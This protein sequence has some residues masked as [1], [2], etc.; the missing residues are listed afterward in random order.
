M[1]A[2]GIDI[3]RKGQLAI[4]T[5]NRPGKKNAFDE[6][7]WDALEDVTT[8]LKEKTP[9]AVIVTGAGEAFSAGFDVN[10]ENPQVSRLVDAVKNRDRSPV[11][12]L[13]NRIRTAVD[14]FVF[15]PVPVIAAVN[16]LAYGGGAELATR[17]DMRIVDPDA[18]FCF[19]ETRLGLMPDWGGGVAL[20]RL[21]GSSRAA[22][23]ILTARKVDAAEAAAMGMVN[24]TSPPGRSL[25]EAIE[26]AERIAA[27]GPSAIRHA[28]SVIR[29]S[30]DL[31]Q[32]NALQLETD[33]AVS[34]ITS[35]EC[36][37]GIM[38]FMNNE[39]PDFPDPEEQK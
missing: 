33:E 21:I 36:Y 2:H 25:D 1:S 26:M 24:R 7:M 29:R 4:V 32:G 35:G 10:P 16:G 27:N 9:R 13:V 18:V 23:L 17:C 30:A 3:D 39:K 38:A 28:L 31:P 34:L 19:S 22:D 15:L 12:A 8:Q 14:N 11:E 37:H 6:K 20:S 5:L